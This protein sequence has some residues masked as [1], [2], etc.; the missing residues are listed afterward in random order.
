MT[1]LDNTMFVTLDTYST[2]L[3][4][5]VTEKR[6]IIKDFLDNVSYEQTISFIEEDDRNFLLANLD[7]L[8]SHI[9]KLN[10]CER[11]STFKYL[12]KKFPYYLTT[13]NMIMF[14]RKDDIFCDEEQ[15]G[16]ENEEQLVCNLIVY[17]L[18]H[19][20]GGRMTIKRGDVDKIEKHLTT[21]GI[22]CNLHDPNSEDYGMELRH[23]FP[24]LD[25][26]MNKTDI[27]CVNKQKISQHKFM[28]ER[29]LYANIL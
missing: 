18:E 5:I 27:E 24:E 10:V 1:T 17:Y 11:V 13:D 23:Y 21:F 12:C 7:I 20:I 28:I 14:L 3:S 29:C 4:E 19:T 8:F 15:I 6:T 16:P 9:W 26:F 25:K 2:L 22:K